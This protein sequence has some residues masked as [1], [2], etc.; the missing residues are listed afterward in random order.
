MTRDDFIDGYIRRSGLST[1]LRTEDGF[2]VG[3]HSRVAVPCDCGE[4]ICREWQMV[5]P[6]DQLDTP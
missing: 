6:N 4:E 2:K 3:A 5:N 1:A